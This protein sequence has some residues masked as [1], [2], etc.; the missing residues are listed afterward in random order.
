MI[1]KKI[2]EAWTRELLPP[3]METQ[4]Q[5]FLLARPR[6]KYIFMVTGIH[7]N[8]ARQILEAASFNSAE[9]FRPYT[10]WLPI[11]FNYH[12]GTARGPLAPRY[13]LW[14]VQSLPA[15]YR[16]LFYPPK[17]WVYICQATTYNDA[18]R[19]LLNA[20]TKNKRLPPREQRAYRL[21]LH[22]ATSGGEKADP[23]Y[24]IPYD[25]VDELF[26]EKIP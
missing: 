6:R 19:I 23:S 20:T 21:H 11:T 4:V 26:V 2:G 3:Q 22:G 9:D 14:S 8:G 5:R 7:T 25:A 12:T 13:G 1:Y 17:E 10:Q 24:H 16:G 18:R 15:E